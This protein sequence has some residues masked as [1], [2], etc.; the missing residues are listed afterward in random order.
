MTFKEMY[1][2]YNE[3]IT[4]EGT[5]LETVLE[6]ARETEVG[7]FTELAGQKN[8]MGKV[9]SAE[10]VGAARIARR[11]FACL[12]PVAAVTAACLCLLITMPV[13]ADSLPY[14][15]KLLN[16]ISPELAEQFVPVQMSDESQGIRMEVVAINL[17]EDGAQVYVTMQDLVGDRLDETTDLYDSYSLHVPFD[18][19]ANCQNLGYDAETKTITF[20]ININAM[21]GAKEDWF[22]KVKNQ[23]ITFSIREIIG[24]KT[25]YEAIEIPIPLAE[26]DLNAEAMSTHLSGGSDWYTEKSG[27]LLDPRPVTRVLR[28]KEGDERFPIGGIEFTGMGYVDGY[29]HVQYGVPNRLENDNHGHFFLRD[30]QGNERM[31]DGK[32]SF[33]GTTEETEHIDY[34]ECIFDISREELD[35]YTLYGYFVTSGL[36]LEGNWEVKF[37]LGD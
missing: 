19:V 24:Q 35:D 34:E 4:P 11:I 27:N 28:P 30:A 14:V 31:Y 29:L 32:V 16:L 10:D 1:Q 12:K 3:K 6:R 37:R 13:L 33:F 15:E 25:E 26:A 2:G 5:V 8:V 22:E 17:K 18:S 23:R 9:D 36:Q 7:K 20:L 21:D